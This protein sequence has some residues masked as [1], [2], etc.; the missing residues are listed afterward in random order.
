MKR[1][2]DDIIG[3][4]ELDN[5]DENE[6]STNNS[7]SAYSRI[8]ARKARKRKRELIIKFVL[9]GVLVLSVVTV[10]AFKVITVPKAASENNDAVVADDKILEATE[11]ETVKKKVYVYPSVSSAYMEMTSAAIKSPYIALLDIEN[12]QVVAGRASDQKIYPASM[13]KVMTLIVAVE[14]IKSLDDKYTFTND[15]LYPLYKDNAS[16]AGFLNDETVTA[17]NMLY[18]LVLPSGA[19]AAVGLA[20]LIAGSEADYAVLMNKKC[21]E[22]G[23]KNTHFMNT[24]GLFDANQYT[25]PVEMAMIMAYAMSNET[26]AKVLSTY[27]YTTDPTPQHPTG[28]PLVSTMFSRMYGTEV[29]GVTITAGKTGYVNESGNC[30]VSYAVKD[31]KH[32]VAVVAGASYKWHVIFDDF[33]IYRNFIPTGTVS[34][35]A[36]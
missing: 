11:P 30:L 21:E 12:N 33:E 13:T 22:L 32:Y 18:G 31:G 10:V 23:L 24:S 36:Q 34:V 27:Q 8:R 29:E 26:C 5:I 6:D 14:N 4:D 17:K 20:K 28:I 1:E 9:T 35:A 16:V 19:D 25:T 2:I 3:F 15:I 7:Q